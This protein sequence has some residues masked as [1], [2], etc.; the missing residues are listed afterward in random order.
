MNK[1]GVLPFDKFLV[2]SCLVDIYVHTT[3]YDGIKI[4]VFHIVLS[5]HSP[6]SFIRLKF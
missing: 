4:L 1:F 2:P 3:H 5:H 6:S